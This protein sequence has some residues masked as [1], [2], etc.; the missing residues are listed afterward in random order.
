VRNEDLRDNF[1]FSNV[2]FNVDPACSDRNG[3]AIPYLLPPALLRGR[4][5]TRVRIRERIVAG[6]QE[7][8]LPEVLRLS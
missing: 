6:P 5:H 1:W 7:T 4:N 2:F 8:R 3:V